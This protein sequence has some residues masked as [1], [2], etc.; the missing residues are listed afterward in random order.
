MFRASQYISSVSMTTFPRNDETQRT[1]SMEIPPPLSKKV[2]RIRGFITSHLSQS[3]SHCLTF[4]LI[5]SNFYISVSTFNIGANGIFSQ[6]PRET[7]FGANS[8]VKKIVETK[9]HQTSFFRIVAVVWPLRTGRYFFR[10]LKAEVPSV[11][12]HQNILTQ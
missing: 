12:N 8:V 7:E 4:C 9:F 6:S 1:H 2:S 5:G 3:L 10:N 11:S